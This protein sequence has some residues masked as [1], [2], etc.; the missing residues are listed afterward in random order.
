MDNLLQ[1]NYLT[2]NKNG[3]IHVNSDGSRIS[4]GGATTYYLTHFPKN[5]IKMKNFWPIEGYAA[6]AP[7]I[8]ATR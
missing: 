8:S 5:C 2:T 3:K 4:Q 6:L 7:P 1:I